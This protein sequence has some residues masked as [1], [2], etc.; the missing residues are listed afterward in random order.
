M[1][2]RSEAFTWGGTFTRCVHDHVGVSVLVEVRDRAR[3]RGAAEAERLIMAGEAARAVTDQQRD[4]GS[5]LRHGKQIEMRIAGELPDECLARL[6][7]RHERP[8]GPEAAV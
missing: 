3:S 2:V 5:V 4:P 8:G 7:D 1:E 6:T